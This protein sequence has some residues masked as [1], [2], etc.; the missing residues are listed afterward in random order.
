LPVIGF[1]NDLP[2]FILDNNEV[3]SVLEIDIEEFINPKN[4]QH[5]RIRN[6]NNLQVNVICYY[7]KNEIIW[8]ASAMIISELVEILKNINLKS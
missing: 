3:D 8:G 4:V 6:R 2:K 1:S 5:K 7:I